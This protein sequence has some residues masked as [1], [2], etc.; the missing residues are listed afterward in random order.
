MKLNCSSDL[1]TW[2]GLGPSPAPSPER[3]EACDQHFRSYGAIERLLVG[4]ARCSVSVDSNTRDTDGHPLGQ[5][6]DLILPSDS[7]ERSA[8]LA[9][10]AAWLSERGC[11]RMQGP[12]CRHTWYAFR[13]VTHGFDAR[14][15]LQGEPWNDPQL[16]PRLMDAGFEEVAW[17]V[18][19]WTVDASRAQIGRSAA[20]RER[21][22]DRGYRVRSFEP[23]RGP[24][25]L[26]F[27]H[28]VTLEAFA[29]PFNYLFH[30]ISLEEF[31]VALGPGLGAIEPRLV[32]LCEDDDGRPAG[33]V[34]GT[35]EGDS[36]SIKTL[37]V[38][39][40]HAG[41]GIGGALV[42]MLHEAALALGYERVIHA[43]MRVGGPST[44]ISDTGDQEIFRRYS[45][46]ERPL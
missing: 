30:P 35:R 26:A 19:T 16:A 24:A 42:A 22:A 18:S 9:L 43:L 13:A 6:G 32:L 36:V 15:P 25:E 17:Y 23:R 38:S 28:A 45:V 20:K 5:I 29:A 40:E 4:N 39:R 31:A 34:Y 12:L 46:L 1:A 7:G 33:Y 3:L 2:L 14:P 10:A 8:L 21:L 27:V 44:H 41:V 11:R 37:A